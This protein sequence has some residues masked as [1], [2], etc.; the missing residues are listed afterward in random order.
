[1]LFISDF[2]D[3][4]LM[5]PLIGLVALVLLVLGRWCDAFAWCLAVVGTL[6]VMGILKILVFVMANP[7][8]GDGLRNPSGHTA[9]GTIVYAGLLALLG[10]RFAS[11]MFIA[12]LA[13]LAFWLIFG[14]SRIALQVHTMADVLV[15]GAVGLGGVVALVRLAGPHRIDTRIADMPIV[16][17]VALTTVL[18][19]HGQ[20]LFAEGKLQAIAAHIQSFV[21]HA[22]N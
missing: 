19:F 10:G 22:F 15:G 17:A 7:Q 3:L 18:T 4:G 13:G 1:M 6:G 2:A 16:A 8:S 14:F 5:L 21:D 20:R 9:S 11:R 12:L